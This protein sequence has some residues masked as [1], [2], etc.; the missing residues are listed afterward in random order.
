[1]RSGKGI[2]KWYNTTKGY[3]FVQVPGETS[4]ILLHCSVLKKSDSAVVSEGDRVVVE[5]GERS[6]G[7]VATYCRFERERRD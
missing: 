7:L 3:G 5:Y 2:V 1:M 6:K 4:D